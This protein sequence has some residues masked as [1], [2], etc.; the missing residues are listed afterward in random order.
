M[1]LSRISVLTANHTAKKPTKTTHSQL[2]KTLKAT[3]MT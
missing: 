2:W 3:F 1:K